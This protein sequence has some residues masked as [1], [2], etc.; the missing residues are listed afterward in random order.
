MTNLTRL[1]IGYSARMQCA[2]Q[3]VVTLFLRSRDGPVTMISALFH[4]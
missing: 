3:V 1:E 4:G 2:G